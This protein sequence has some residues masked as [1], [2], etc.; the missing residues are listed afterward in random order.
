MTHWGRPQLKRSIHVLSSI[1]SSP[2]TLPPLK[3]ASQQTMT[4]MWR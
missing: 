3:T 4:M 2:H 1:S